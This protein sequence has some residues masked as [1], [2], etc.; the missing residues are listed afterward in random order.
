M[1]Q[2]ALSRVIRAAGQG[3]DKVGIMLEMNPHI[4]RCKCA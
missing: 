1:I 3:L 2:G 4:E